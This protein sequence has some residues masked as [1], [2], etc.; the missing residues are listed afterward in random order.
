[1]YRQLVENVIYLTTTRP[2]LAYAINVLSQFMSKPLKSH[3]VAVKYDLIYFQGTLD[4]GIIYINSF[5]VRLIGLS[6][7]DWARNLDD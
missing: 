3:W 7:S 2:G 4:F 6:D 5:D 1:M